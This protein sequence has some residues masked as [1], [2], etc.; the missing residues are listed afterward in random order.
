[1][2]RPA[3]DRGSE[4]NDEGIIP[5]SD[6]LLIELENGSYATLPLKELGMIRRTFDGG[7]GW[8]PLSIYSHEG[9]PNLELDFCDVNL[10]PIQVRGEFEEYGGTLLRDDTV[11]PYFD[12]WRLSIYSCGVRLSK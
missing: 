5:R 3:N 12:G 9:D 2:V 10:T 4:S 11:G 1:M 8:H 6:L 7:Q